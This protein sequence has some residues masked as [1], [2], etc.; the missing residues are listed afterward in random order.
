MNENAKIN[1]LNLLNAA[2]ADECSRD[3]YVCGHGY[4]IQ[5]GIERTLRELGYM[6]DWEDNEDGDPVAVNIF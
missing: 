5:K 6:V 4:G 2:V 1:V 3:Q